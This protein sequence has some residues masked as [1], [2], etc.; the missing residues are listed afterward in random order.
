MSVVELTYHGHACFGITVDGTN[1]L[2]DPFLT[3]NPL[4][5]ISAEEAEADFVLIGPG[6]PTYAVRQWKQTPIPEILIKNVMEGGC[7]VAA[8]AAAL[9]QHLRYLQRFLEIRSPHN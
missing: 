2:I 5:D 3:G 1:L 8:S 9:T 6:S 4:A 7:L